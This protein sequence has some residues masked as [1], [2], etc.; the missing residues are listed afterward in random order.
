M[1]TVEINLNGKRALVTGGNTGIGKAIVTRLAAAGARVVVNYIVHPEAASALV[2]SLNGQYGKGKALAIEAD[3]SK[4][5]DVIRL[6]KQ[7]GEALGGL[8]I[9]VNNAG[10][11]SMYAAVDM[12]MSEWDRVQGVNLRGPFMCARTFAAMAIAQGTG[13]VVINNSS[14]HDVVPRAGAAHYNSSKA[15]LTMLTKELAL[16]WGENGIR[17]V[18][19]SP[20]AIDSHREGYHVGDSW[21]N[22]FT[23]WVPLKRVGE[24]DE[25]ANTVVFL[26][27]D[28]ASYITGYT[29]YIDGGYGINLM[30]YDPRKWEMFSQAEKK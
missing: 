2:E 25:V 28:L 3:I 13:G 19:V 7:A 27:S 30:R 20:G 22:Y 6:F 1:Q 18:G 10:T 11:E 29:I 5:E 9:L 21:K 15:G 24:V 16:E 8:D 12:P 17:V 23:D 14:M 4:E 26:A